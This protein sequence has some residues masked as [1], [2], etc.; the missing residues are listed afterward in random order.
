MDRRH[1]VL[2]LLA[3]LLALAAPA[4]AQSPEGV[5]LPV[6]EVEPDAGAPP[7]LGE[8]PLF[9]PAPET[10]APPCHFCGGGFTTSWG[11]APSHWGHGPDCASAQADVRSQLL[12]FINDDCQNYGTAG[13][14]SFQV[15]Y[16]CSCYQEGGQWVV[17][18]YANYG[19][20]V[21]FC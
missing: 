7:E 18:A 2:V 21:Y 17:D 10:K 4:V 6:A 19:C 20:W 11:G 15:V 1:L 14:C 3:V 8:G 13:R 5:A 12:A 16:T 9:T